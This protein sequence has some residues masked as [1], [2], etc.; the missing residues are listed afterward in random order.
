MQLGISSAGLVL[1]RSSTIAGDRP[2]LHSTHRRR[3]LTM[4]PDHYGGRQI[5][6]SAGTDS[7]ELLESP[8]AQ[9]P[10]PGS[11]FHISRHNTALS[12]RSDKRKAQ[13]GNPTRISK[14]TS[15]SS[16]STVTTVEV[17]ASASSTHSTEPSEAAPR[18]QLAKMLYNNDSREP[19][20]GGANLAPLDPPA[21]NTFVRGG[22]GAS[23]LS[24]A[25]IL[26]RTKRGGSGGDSRLGD[27]KGALIRPPTMDLFGTRSRNNVGDLQASSGGAYDD[28]DLRGGVA[29]SGPVESSGVYMPSSAEQTMPHARHAQPMRG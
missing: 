7:G 29:H 10:V 25:G 21:L 9:Q 22:A 26:G 23:G 20:V 18:G 14:T 6:A 3:G 15:G 2:D 8:V 12:A 11:H 5:S 4:D 19:G 1:E 24:S 13:A 16:N 27:Y 28:P 17:D